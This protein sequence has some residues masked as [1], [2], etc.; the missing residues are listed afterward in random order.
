MGMAEA[1]A[2]TW[3]SSVAVGT[4]A[5]GEGAAACSTETLAVA[6]VSSLGALATTS[7]GAE[8]STMSV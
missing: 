7:A 3:T 6:A 4:P 5:A 8:I 2:G 1:A